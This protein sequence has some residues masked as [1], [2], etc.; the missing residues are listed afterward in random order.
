MSV[1][2]KRGDRVRITCCGVQKEG[3]VLTANN[4]GDRDY[5]KQPPVFTR[6]DWYINMI[7]D[8]D[9]YVYWKQGIDGGSVEVTKEA[10]V[11]DPY[12]VW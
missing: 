2:I 9:S 6:D 5:S 8:D 7:A 10:N 11:G 4:Y 3:V 12:R 1:S